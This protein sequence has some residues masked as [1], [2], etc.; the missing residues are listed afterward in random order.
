VESWTAELLSLLSKQTHS[1]PPLI[2]WEP[3]PPQCNIA[4]RDAHLLGCKHVDV[5]SPNHLELAKLFEDDDQISSGF[6]REA[7]ESYAE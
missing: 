7:I 1:K 2:V 6:D 5:F 3:A 4:N